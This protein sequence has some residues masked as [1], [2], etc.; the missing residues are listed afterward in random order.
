MKITKS[1]LLVLIV[2]SIVLMIRRTDSFLNPQFWAE[3]GVLFFIQQYEYGL[4][5]VFKPYA[6]Y[7]HIIPRLVALFADSFFSY[8]LI[9]SVYNL[10]CFAITLFVIANLFSPRLTIRNNA[11]FALAIV[12][13]P[14]FTNEVFMNLT[15]IQWIVS[16]LLIVTLMKEDPNRKYGNTNCQYIFDI[17]IIILC[18]LTGPFIIFL[19]P[20]FVLRWIKNINYYNDLILILTCLISLIQLSLILSEIGGSNHINMPLDLNIYSSLLGQKIFGNLILGKTAPYFLNHYLLSIIYLGFI[21][22]IFHYQTQEKFIAI[23]LYTH[24]IILLAIFYKFKS[25]PDILIAAENGVRYFYIPYL[26][27]AWILIALLDQK[28]KWKKLIATTALVFILVSSFSSGLHSREFID[29]KWRNYCRSIGK[30]DVKIPINPKGW[31]IFIK[32]HK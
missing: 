21:F 27:I 15:N 11:L 30:E 22:V 28:E 1:N 6:G 23:F 5:A 17:S 18:G 29:Y 12:L 32:A 19:L 31:H 9:P 4:P 8:S 7:L 3:D 20:L 24:L 10:S 26:M 25:N 2:A 16:I 13:I 14:H